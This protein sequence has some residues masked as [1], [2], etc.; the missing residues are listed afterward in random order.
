MSTLKPGQFEIKTEFDKAEQP[1][2]GDSVRV[3][4]LNTLTEP[5]VKKFELS[6][7]NQE[8]KGSYAAVKKKYGALAVTDPERASRSKQDSRFSLN[9]LLRDPLSVEEEERRVIEERVRVRVEAL[10]EEVKRKSEAVGY[11][12]G[13]KKGHTEA[14]SKFLEEGAGRLQRFEAFLAE[15]ESAKEQIFRANERFLVEVVFR[16]AKMLLLKELAADKEYVLR[17]AR[18]LIERVGVRENIT[19][20]IS[21]EDAQTANLFKEGLEKSLGIL[22]NVDIQISNQVKGGG[23]MIETEWNAIDASVETQLQGVYSALVG[24][25]TGGPT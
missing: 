6:K 17:L 2:K 20:R 25:E 5:S 9:P 22:K 21:P 8:Q 7:L 3:V 14:Y 16:I 4:K 15:I 12:A 10:S 13:L 23:C 19:I 18:E 11:E 24:V 1:V